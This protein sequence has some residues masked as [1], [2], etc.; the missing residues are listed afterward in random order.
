VTSGES[1]LKELNFHLELSEDDYRVKMRHAEEALWSGGKVKLQLKFRGREMPRLEEGIALV[2][3]MI[4]DLSGIGV[5]D[6][7]PRRIGKSI[8]LMLS[9]LP[10]NKRVRKFSH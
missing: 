7:E 5:A 9:P 1:N 6:V 2:R 10:P 4:L 3:R 8:N